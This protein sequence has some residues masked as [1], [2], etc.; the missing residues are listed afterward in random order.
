MSV[1]SQ[2]LAVSVTH[3]P[4]YLKQHLRQRQAQ[5]P[6]RA[7]PRE[8]HILGPHGRMRRP[9]RGVQQV[10]VGDEAVEE[11]SGEGM[12]GREAVPDA[13]GAAAARLGEARHDGPVRGRVAHVHCAAVD[14]EDCGVGRG[15]VED[16]VV[17][18]AF[19]E[20]RG[21]AGVLWD[22]GAGAGPFCFYWG[23]CGE[24]VVLLVFGGGGSGGV[25]GGG[26]EGFDTRA[27]QVAELVDAA[28]RRVW[29]CGRGRGGGEGEF[30]DPHLASDA[31]LAAELLLLGDCGGG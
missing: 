2:S 20:V 5:I 26:F 24:S 15:L 25:G 9:R 21:L 7:V 23:E 1:E 13:Q 27:E 6:A 19:G 18:V 17:L 11:G 8:N 31:A 28:V 10:Q 12:R 14:V 30:G 4:L 22:A 29:A 3:I 16:A